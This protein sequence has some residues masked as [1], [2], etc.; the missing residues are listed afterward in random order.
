[1]PVGSTPE[2]ISGHYRRVSPSNVNAVADTFADAWQD[3]EIPRRQ[4]ESVVKQ[5]LEDL[6]AG[7]W[8]A[9]F[10]ALREIF[11]QIRGTGPK[12][13]LLDVG[14]SSGYYSSVL[15]AI[16]YRGAYTA[17]DWSTYYADLARELYSEIDFKVGSATEL[18]FEDRS[19]DIV[20]HGACLM[21]LKDH[22]KAIWEAARVSRGLVIFHRT[23]VYTDDTPTEAFVKTAYGTP[24]L[25]WAFNK[26][27]LLGLFYGCGLEPISSVD[28][29]MDGTFGHRSYLLKKIEL[30][31]HP[32]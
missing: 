26:Y 24:C 17:L 32:V 2:I 25:E 29:F 8:S 13:S 14:A 19:F 21:H 7:K 30:Q 10:A 15:S 5:E 27:E 18:P 23:P 4:Y 12:D 3:P 28:V 31:H 11:G 9:P 6:K 20:L 16:G 22:R 1:M